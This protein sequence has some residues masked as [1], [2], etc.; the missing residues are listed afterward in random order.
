MPSPLPDRFASRAWLAWGLLLAG[1]AATAA[2]TH[3]ALSAAR[4][5][6][7]RAHDHAAGQV[8]AAI[9]ARLRA[10][11]D[12]I[13]AVRGHVAAGGATP[14]AFERFV[15]ALDA[16]QRFP[17][18]QNL[19]Y[20]EYVPAAGRAAFEQRMRRHGGVYRDYAVAADGARDEHLAVA[21]RATVGAWQPMLGNDLLAEPARREAIAAARDSGELVAAGPLALLR[22]AGREAWLLYLPVYRPGRTDTV[23]ARRARFAGVVRATFRVEDL[24]IGI[25]RG[26]AQSPQRFALFEAGADGGRLLYDSAGALAAGAA[27]AAFGASGAT[28]TLEFGG[29]Q[30]RALFAPPPPPAP[31]VWALP[32]AAGAAIS[33][34]LFALVVALTR[35]SGRARALAELTV[36]RLRISESRIA[37][38]EAF[39]SVMVL[40]AALDGRLLRVPPVF[41]R[42]LG[43]DEAALLARR[44]DDLIHPQHGA[45]WKQ[46]LAALTGGRIKSADCEKRCMR[47]DGG[48][49]WLALSCTLVADDDDA[50]VQLLIYA[51]DVTARVQADAELRR[52]HGELEHQVEQRTA[53]LQ[54]ANR[55]LE[56]FSYSVSHDLRASVRHISGFA[57]ILEREL[58]AQA[59]A[60]ARR[61]CE[62]IGAAAAR[63]GELIDDLLFFARA[64]RAELRLAMLDM[65]AAVQRALDELAPELAAR[66]VEFAIAPLPAV[67]ADR[68]LLHQVWVNLLSNAIK[69]T[70]ARACAHVAVG[71]TAAAAGEIA[72]FVRDDGVGFDPAGAG[73]LFG[74]FQR[75]HAREE[76]EG[77]GVGLATVQRIVH[78]HGGRVWAESRP[79]AGATF[80]FALPAAP[81]AP[82]ADSA[83]A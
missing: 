17:G 51:R 4:E 46:Q 24:M 61:C 77:N 63:M 53:Q 19:L 38:T 27:P 11:A 14:A 23:E 31:A 81:A 49:L 79:G 45:A 50:P 83:S 60:E 16:P 20:A 22:V 9:D 40:H 57:R 1:L 25:A 66:R 68:G 55:E 37:R 35:A 12:V 72:F 58:G 52:L 33:L 80:Y 32:L 28:R 73:R 74:V 15:D 44:L 67:L 75:L 78:R 41:C 13:Y 7:A 5:A 56:S 36:R 34:L 82:R 6:A 71:V 10:S 59:T 48:E 47:A 65:N 21:L 8:V 76:F 30:W 26:E 3:G 69:Y 54:A 39:S 43:F 18:L 29:Q 70:A 2:F 62:R 64:S 42:L